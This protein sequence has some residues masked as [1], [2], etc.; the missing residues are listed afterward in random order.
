MKSNTKHAAATATA[1]A[2][3]AAPVEASATEETKSLATRRREWREVGNELADVLANPNTPAGVF[4]GIGEAIAEMANEEHISWT[5]PDILRAVYPV[6]VEINETGQVSRELEHETLTEFYE[7]LASTI[8]DALE[9]TSVPKKLKDALT[10]FYI[11]LDG[12]VVGDVE[13]Q[14]IEIRATL[15]SICQAFA[16]KKGGRKDEN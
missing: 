13:R 2:L 1:P 8:A 12:E 6:I 9:R 15:P 11:E 10:K 14:A 16:G 3:Q 7:R 5:H 4:E